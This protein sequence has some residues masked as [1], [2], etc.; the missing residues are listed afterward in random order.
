MRFGNVAS[1]QFEWAVL[2]ESNSITQSNETDRLDRVLATHF[3]LAAFRPMQRE[4][5]ESALAGRDT[6]VVMPTGGGKSLC[7]QLPAL[8]LPGITLVISPLIALMQ[9]Q[10]DRLQKLRIPAIALNST[11]TYAQSRA[12]IRRAQTGEIKVIFAAPER[13]ESSPFREELA[14]LNI[15]L[16]A[17]DEAHCISEWGHDFRTSYRRLPQSFEMFGANERSNGKRPPIIALT[18]TATPEVRADIVKLLTLSDPLEIVTGFE[19]PNLSYGVLRESDKESR[20][21]DIIASTAHGSA[22]VYG[23]TRKSVEAITRM[24]RQFGH[25][26]DSYHAGVPLELRKNVQD[27]FLSGK[28]PIIVATS[29][30]GMG[31]DKPDVRVVVHYDVP[32][33]IE[34]YYQEAGRA[35]RDGNPAHA[36][37]FFNSNDAR[38]QEFLIRSNFPTEAEIKAVY[39]ALHEIAGN[40]IGSIYPGIL[41]TDN[42]AIAQRIVKPNSSIERIVEVLE[43]SGHV[44]Y[45]RGLSRDGRA[46][47]R[48][49]APNTRI[50]EVIFKSNSKH[51]KDTLGALVRTLGP[52]AFEKEVFLDEHALLEHRSL[53]RDNFLL[54]IRTAEGLG[55]LRYTTAM[56]PKSGI[57]IYHLS[58]PIERLPL[59]Y[60]DVGAKELELRLEANLQKLQAMVAYASE[61][62]CRRNTILHY[63]GEH[64]HG[65]YCGTCDVCV[66][67][68]R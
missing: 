6:L 11:L 28:T 3:H 2:S 49:T 14:S 23:S 7:Y 8:L 12:L 63:F 35:G 45:H 27:N 26:A 51:L 40:A 13:L 60:L 55:L 29:A 21:R 16:L 64:P 33:S 9:D 47:I 67:R 68:S 65:L 15:S 18:A 24:L 50:N 46:R 30:F 31:V 4:A 38:T 32:G 48:F 39:H 58:L 20:L 34:A 61:W 17:I 43:R 19:R 62:S 1:S 53:D 42:R 37:L 10:V 54:A 52:E 41:V 57:T 44:H 5:I 36:I 66:A 56:R 25:V 22:I 59:Q